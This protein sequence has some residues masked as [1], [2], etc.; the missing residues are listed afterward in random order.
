[1]KHFIQFFLFFFVIFVTMYKCHEPSPTFQIQG[2]VSIEKGIN[3]LDCRNALVQSIKENIGGQ[4]DFDHFE[5][6]TDGIGEFTITV[7]PDVIENNQINCFLRIIDNK[8]SVYKIVHINQMIP[9]NKIIVIDKDIILD[10]KAPQ[11]F[12]KYAFNK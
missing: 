9:P 8:N 2:K 6:Q 12:Q 5:A 10:N 3:L 7:R 1:M 11:C 4:C